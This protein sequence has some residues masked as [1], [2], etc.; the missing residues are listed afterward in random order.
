MQV[1]QPQQRSL[2]EMSG[3]CSQKSRAV[4]AT[5]AG[6]QAMAQ[7]PQGRDRTAIQQQLDAS[8]R[9]R[10][11][12][13]SEHYLLPQPDRATL[14]QRNRGKPSAALTSP[15][16]RNIHDIKHAARLIAVPMPRYF[17]TRHSDHSVIPSCSL[18]VCLWLKPG[19]QPGGLWGL[20]ANCCEMC[21]SGG[22]EL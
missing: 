9:Q 18:H 13:T 4:E 3:Q 10:W 19:A 5:A 20:T 6:A 16:T 12:W 21:L 14:P 2:P 7:G 11:T 1:P 8:H 15:Q 22:N 17:Q